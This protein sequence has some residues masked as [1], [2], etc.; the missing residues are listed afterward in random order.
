MQQPPNPGEPEPGTPVPPL[1][2]QPT[3]IPPETPTRDPDID[4][5]SPGIQPPTG[6]VAPVG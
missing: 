2:G 5:P 1:P 4:V 6:P 3:P